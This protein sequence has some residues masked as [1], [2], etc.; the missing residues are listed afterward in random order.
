MTAPETRAV[1]RG[2]LWAIFGVVAL[3]GYALD[4]AS[5]AW[6]VANLDPANP[7]AYLGGFLKLRLVFN[8]GAAFSFGSS[9]TV[10]FSILA[11]VALL[12]VLIGFAPRLPDRWSAVVAGLA[13][14]GIAGNFTDRMLRAPGPFRGHV[15]DFFQI[16]HWAIFN[17]AD[18][19][20][21]AVAV[22]VVLRALFSP[23]PDPDARTSTTGASGDDASAPALGADLVEDAEAA[24]AT[25]PT[26][27]A[28]AVADHRGGGAS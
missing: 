7:P 6:A 22:L 18:I 11:L 5:K 19:C 17:V 15:V 8:P 16:P 4:Q 21:S 26:T 10:F 3:V 2:R 20:I 13:A 25:E 9:A 14:A 1:N 27:D 12:V 28:E 24:P 23:K